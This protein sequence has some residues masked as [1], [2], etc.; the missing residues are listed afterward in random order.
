M[1]GYGWRCDNCGATVIETHDNARFSQQPP[2]G[3]YVVYHD[4][5][6]AVADNVAHDQEWHF[7]SMQC[8]DVWSRMLHHHKEELK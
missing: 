6:V 1:R 8:L 5:G 2:Q 7:C 4:I 3:W